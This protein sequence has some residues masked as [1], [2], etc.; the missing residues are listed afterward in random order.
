M[1]RHSGTIISFAW[2]AILN[3]MHPRVQLA[4]LAARARFKEPDAFLQGCTAASCGPV[5]TDIQD[6][7][8]PRAE[9]SICPCFVRLYCVEKANAA[10]KEKAETKT[11]STAGHT[12]L[13]LGSN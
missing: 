5:Y 13:L 1:L 8:V 9:S 3:L 10:I 11:F 7:T 6:S 12:K 2:L 4:L